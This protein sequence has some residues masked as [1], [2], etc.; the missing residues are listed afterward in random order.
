MNGNCGSR[1]ADCGIG[2]AIHG[3]RLR[4]AEAPCARRVLRI[5][6]RARAFTLIEIVLAI[7]ISIALAAAVLGFYQQ[8]SAVRADFDGQLREV[9]VAAAHRAV[10][11]RM[12]E[13]LRSAVAYPSVMGL[14]GGQTEL[15]WVVAAV[16][17]PAAWAVRKITDEPV[18]PEQDLRM[19]GFR[20][21][22]YENDAGDWIVEGLERLE[23]RL[24]TA[25][26]TEEGEQIRSTLM[27]PQFKFLALRYWDAGGGQWVTSWSSGGLP[28]AVEISLGREPLPENTV[29][30]EYPY[31]TVRRV[32]CVPGA[33]RAPQGGTVIRGLGG[34]R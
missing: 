6:S 12:T 28:A 27:A 22:Q 21:R 30:E 19:V 16:P 8:V 32:V 2:S 29:P 18:P 17:G 4:C 11:D 24:L 7:G 20:I 23:Q 31:P 13:E 33:S 26:V 9:Q 5:A 10:M 1:I 25:R 15:R 34:G 14:H 3:S